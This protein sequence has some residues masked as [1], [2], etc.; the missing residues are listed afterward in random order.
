MTNGNRSTA[1]SENERI[2]DARPNSQRTRIPVPRS[3]RGSIDS[4]VP[5]VPG[6][7]V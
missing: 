7:S 1:T 3:S 4:Q 2:R 6:L 5:E